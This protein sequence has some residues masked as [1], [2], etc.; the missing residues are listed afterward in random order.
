MV[1]PHCLHPMMRL[2]SSNNYTH[3]IFYRCYYCHS[4]KPLCPSEDSRQS[5]YSVGV[6]S[7]DQ[8]VI[9]EFSQFLLGCNNSVS[10]THLDVYKRQTQLHI[11]SPLLLCPHQYFSKF[12]SIT[13]FS[14]QYYIIFI[15]TISTS[16]WTDLH[17]P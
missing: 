7:P 17:V 12:Y 13:L 6:Y 16:T 15:P 9:I 10:Y 4:S 5:L 1:R 14:K 8:K 2:P 11:N 3:S